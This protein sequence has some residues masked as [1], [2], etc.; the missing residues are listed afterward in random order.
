MA[1]KG[2]S[3][4]K[5]SDVEVWMKQKC[6][7]EFLH[8][9]KSGI[10]WHSSMFAECLWQPNRGCEH[11]GAVG[12]AFQQCWQWVTSTGSDFY[13]QGI[14]GENAQLMVLP[15]LKISIS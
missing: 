15:M 5:A 4:K 12:G 1:A 9:E 8:V 11:S 10:H 6:V 7:T 13:E 14:T 3:D 2:Q